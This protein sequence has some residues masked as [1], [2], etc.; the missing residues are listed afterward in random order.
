MRGFFNAVFSRPTLSLTLIAAYLS[1]IIFLC[2]YIPSLLSFGA[3]VAGVYVLSAS[4]ALT[5]VC[6]DRPPEYKCAWLCFI[7]AV[8]VVGAVMYVIFKY[9][10]K[11]CERTLNFVGRSVPPRI[12]YDDCAYFADGAGY[13]ERLF[14]E[15]ERAEINVYLEY[16]IIA[17]GEIFS[18]LHDCLARALARGVEVKII[19]DGLGSA[20]RLP[21]RRLKELERGGAELCIF[22]RLSPLPASRL[23]FRDHRKIAAIDGKI[24]FLGGINIA[25]EYAGI[26]SPHGYWK[27][28]GFC[29]TGK[30]AEFFKEL[31]LSVWSGCREIS[32]PDARDGE[33]LFLP[34]YDSPPVQSGLCED[35][36]CAAIYAAKKR[37]WAFTP[38][39]CLDER[40]KK[41]FTFAAAR[42][43]D[44]II[45]I[46]HVPDKK[47]AFRLTLAYS[48]ELQARG[49]K[50]YEYTPGFMHAKCV[51]CDDKCILGSYN[52]DFRSMSLNY[53]CGGAFDGKIVD[54]VAKDFTDCL[55]L[56]Q[57]EK[58]C[59]KNKC[60]AL[61]KLFA[62]LA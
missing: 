51:I 44:V 32:P 48:A 37:V 61:L 46:P 25:D 22:H 35:V 21:R 29:I 11:A 50:I 6:G 17:E 41:A 49:V 43:A 24:A 13:F 20:L 59:A 26:T 54:E 23:N 47:L 36:L 4:V 39:L 52:L 42:G 62:P 38:Y 31:F 5:L 34:V 16:Y 53:E 7:A 33:K 27:D 2:F 1:A 55:A 56:S 30:A 12:S 19:A 40:L 57:P 60:S 14:A 15:I 28:T 45:I 8:P 10:S 9:R 58:P 18:R 3:A